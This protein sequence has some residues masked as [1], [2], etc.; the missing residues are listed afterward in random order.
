[1]VVD[2]LGVAVARL[3]DGR[4]HALRDICPHQAGMLSLGIVFPFVSSEDVGQYDV[5]DSRFILRC[6]WHGFE[7]DTE[8]GRCVAD[9]ERYRVRAY[10]AWVDDD[11]VVLER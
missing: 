3:P 7:F 11:Q 8:S 2:G 4:V 1:M 10:K 5:S 6:P 9:P